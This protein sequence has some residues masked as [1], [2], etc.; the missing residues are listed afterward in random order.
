[1]ENV[2]K[3]KSCIEI[4]LAVAHQ[5]TASLHNRSLHNGTDN[6]D[7]PRIVPP[8]AAMNYFVHFT[9]NND[10]KLIEVSAKRCC[11]QKKIV[12]VVVDSFSTFCF[13]TQTKHD[14]EQYWVSRWF[15]HIIDNDNEIQ[16]EARKM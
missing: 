2:V 7:S 4:F 15:G 6:D 10:L 14:S 16:F 9:F 13:A 3:W 11:D 1:M 5:G 8:D 12:F